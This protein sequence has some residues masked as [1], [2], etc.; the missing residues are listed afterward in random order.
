MYLILCYN[1]CMFSPVLLPEQSLVI[2]YYWHEDELWLL[3]GQK[4]RGFGAGEMVFPGGKP[5]GHESSSETAI[6]EL[7][8]ET[9]LVISPAELKFLGRLVLASS[10]PVES[11]VHVYGAEVILGT[12]S[13]PS[14]P[15]IDS[16]DIRNLKW[17]RYG[18]DFDAS[19]CPKDYA[20]WIVFALAAIESHTFGIHFISRIERDKAGTMLQQTMLLENDKAIAALPQFSYA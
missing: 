13:G 14:E 2:P 16:S 4:L 17:M 12:P 1:I 19:A 5:T 9:G 7:H 3:A 15:Q 6:R 18:Q 10:E 8:E 11:Q 20:G